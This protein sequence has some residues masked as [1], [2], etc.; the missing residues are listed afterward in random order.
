MLDLLR[1]YLFTFSEIVLLSTL[2]MFLVGQTFLIEGQSMEPTIKDGQRIFAEKI[3]PFFAHL[4]TGEIVVFKN[5][6][7]PSQYLIKRVIAVGGDE[8]IIF[9]STIYLN[10]KLLFENYVKEP[11]YLPRY[12]KVLV[13]R[14]HYYLLGDNRN[15]STDSRNL[16]V[17]PKENIVGRL[18]FSVW[19]IKF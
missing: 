12:T 17:V 14:N 1:R 5:P 18:L 13:P 9:D 3:S 2:F 6:Q 11:V 10:G 19:P 15:Q 7:N 8:L 4:K 16:G